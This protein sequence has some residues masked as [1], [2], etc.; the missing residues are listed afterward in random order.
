VSSIDVLSGLPVLFG[1]SSLV[2]RSDTVIFN[3]PQPLL[4]KEGREVLPPYF[5][6]GVSGWSS[7]D[8]LIPNFK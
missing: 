2:V 1:L 7:H 6:E 4:E 5:K 3:H 8:C